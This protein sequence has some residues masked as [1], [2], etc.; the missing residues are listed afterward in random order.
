MHVNIIAPNNQLRITIV[1]NLMQNAVCHILRNLSFQIYWLSYEEKWGKR[2]RKFT[3]VR[4]IIRRRL[5]DE[6]VV[7]SYT[8]CPTK[9]HTYLLTPWCRVLL[10]KLTGLQLVK[11]FPAFHGTRRFTTALTSVIHLSLSWA[12]PIQS[13]SSHLLEIHL[14]VI[15][16]LRLGLPSGLL[17]SGFPTNTLNTH[18]P[19]PYVPH[20]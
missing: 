15:H 12:S 4:F 7:D 1:C 13:I 10:E 9:D 3:K 20:A 2:E 16:H 14:N 17:P 8:G 18:S 5:T 19:H 11:K 6:F